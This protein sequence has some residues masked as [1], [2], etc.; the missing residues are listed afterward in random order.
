M[1]RRTGPRAGLPPG[2]AP[3]GAPG[4]P[5]DRWAAATGHD[6]RQSLQAAT[7]QA[8]ALMLQARQQA[9]PGWAQL[10]AQMAES[11]QHCQRLLE[12]LLASL[13]PTPH[14]LPPAGAPPPDWQAV[15]LGALLD[16]LLR[17]WQ[18][19]ADQRGLRLTLQRPDPAP[20]VLSDALLLRRVLDNLVGNAL[21]YTGT[22]TDADTDADTGGVALQLQWLPAADS[23]LGGLLLTV[24]DSGAGLPADRPG[25][26]RNA[27]GH[28]L[29]LMI[30]RG[31]CAQLGISF[32]LQ[33]QAGAGT[34]ARLAW[35]ATAVTGLARPN[36]D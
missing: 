1:P 15:D 4:L 35:V 16:A 36:G 10:G 8:H 6:L 9:L 28:G 25:L 17:A 27:A 26:P 18:P 29:G 12:N 11:L 2:P 5:A 24:S 34:V 13:A 20:S 32:D 19:T 3:G 23:G 14:S 31:L 22:D 33:G 7:V 21:A 30:A